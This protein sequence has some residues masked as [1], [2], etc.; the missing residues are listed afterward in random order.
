[1]L[2]VKHLSKDSFMALLKHIIKDV[3]VRKVYFSQKEPRPDG[4]TTLM[5]SASLDIP[6]SGRKHMNFA[7]AGEIKDQFLSPGEIHFCPPMHWKNPLWDS[8]HEM[9][10]IVYHPDYVRLTYINYNRLSTYFDSH[11]AKI[12]YHTS[13][14]LE[15]AGTSILRTLTLMADSGIE[16][17]AEDLIS[18]LLKI[19]LRTLEKDTF[20]FTGKAQKTCIQI[21][22]YVQDNFSSP[23]NRAH[24]A[25]VFKINPSYISRLFN[26]QGQESFNSMLR[27]L[28][29][30]HAALLIKQTNLSIDEITDS[31]GYLSSTYFIS[32]FHKH[33]GVSPGK[34]RNL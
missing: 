4:K 16:D 11:S 22:Q 28:R 8:L 26:E 12:S 15:I 10:S 33:F 19:T 18:A 30:E 5:T 14:P 32:A 13:I 29:L 24:V 20:T 1:M 21:K 9:S 6:L 17:G 23:I 34:Y 2:K 3:G 7:G 27:R 25:S 31:C